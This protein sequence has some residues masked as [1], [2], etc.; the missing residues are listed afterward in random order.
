MIFQHARCHNVLYL[1][2][3]VSGEQALPHLSAVL[4]NVTDSSQSSSDQ[5]L[6]GLM[7]DNTADLADSINLQDSITSAVQ[8]LLNSTED[9]AADD[10]ASQNVHADRPDANSNSS[11][12]T[13]H[14]VAESHADVPYQSEADDFASASQS[15]PRQSV[16]QEGPASSDAT[17]A[18]QVSDSRFVTQQQM[19]ESGHADAFAKI[20]ES[21]PDHV[22]NAGSEGNAP[23]NNE[24]PTSERTDSASAG[25]GHTSG[26]QHHQHAEL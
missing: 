12:H 8:N 2:Q 26:T 1:L 15:E 19:D 10:S 16:P 21:I 7:P 6:Q 11:D 20:M 22:K 3:V 17:V 4:N 25:S 9:A 5:H 14:D 23:A 24:T 18:D 13:S